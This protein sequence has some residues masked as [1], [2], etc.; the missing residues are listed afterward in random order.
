[1]AQKRIVIAETH[2]WQDPILEVSNAGT[3]TK[4]N[5]YIVGA[6]PTGTFDG[7]TT[8]DI[9]WY[10]GTAWQTD[11]PTEGWVV[12]DK[13]ENEHLLFNGT[14]WVSFIPEGTGEANT[15]SNVGTGGVGVFKQKEGVDL[16]FKNIGAG[17]DKV[18]VTNNTEDDRVDI[19]VDES[20]IDHNALNNY[21]ANEHVPTVFD[22]DLGYVLM[23]FPE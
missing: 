15:A 23:D 17:S 4:G 13:D 18:T 3:A 11:T 22:A 20:E 8:H 10:D 16:E 5:R 19:D 1:M 6:A 21:E 9:A 7:L 12:Y 2:A 14:A